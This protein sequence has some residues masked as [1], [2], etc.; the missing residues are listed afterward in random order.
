MGRGIVVLA[1][2]PRNRI[3][4]A[5]ASFDAPLEITVI[6]YCLPLSIGTPYTQVPLL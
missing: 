4:L 5:G 3:Q 2:L 1:S 6:R